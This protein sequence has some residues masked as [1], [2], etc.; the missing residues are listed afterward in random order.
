MK[1][2]GTVAALVVGVMLGATVS[3]VAEAS[4]SPP[5]NLKKVG[6]HWTAWDPPAAGP[7]AYIVVK[8]DTLWDLAE[9]WFGDPF[10][11][12]Q[13][14]D[15][16]RYILDSHWIYPGDP[17]VIPGRP[18]VVPAE[19]PPPVAEDA[20]AATQPKDPGF[21]RTAVTPDAPRVVELP[22]PPPP[23]MPAA[24]P[25]DLYCTGFIAGEREGSSLTI[26]GG[27]N[28]RLGVA[29]GD[30]VFLSHGRDHGIRAGD[31]Y[32]IQRATRDIRHPTTGVRL[33]SLVRRLGRV[34]VM[35][36]HD[37]V[38]TA[39]IENSCEDIHPGD[40]LVAWVDIPVPMLESVPTL[41]RYDPTPSGG[42]VGAVV[43]A[44]DGVIALGAGHVIYTD[45]G[46]GIVTPGDVLT[47]Y[48]ERE[49]P[50]P[51]RTLGQAIVLTVEP[52][53]STAKVIES[54]SETY[55]GDAVEVVR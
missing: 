8:G 9:K 50:H 30:V 42:S 36:V 12:P 18:T 49:A 46:R 15:E 55:V 32:Q 23:L 14:W 21:G 25:Q 1:R 52:G 43:A 35:L 10:L 51:R 4:T 53:T 39:L 47:I 6:D 40:E 44:K 2:T 54:V 5:T 28:E 27:D 17:L 45:L 34:R 20:A 33:G 38:S 16:N 22:P 26:T 3:L 24:D 37:E 13:V 11:W 48:R 19:E 7:D 31:E 41:Q 29:E